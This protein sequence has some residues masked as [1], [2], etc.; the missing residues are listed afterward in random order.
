[1]IQ[2]WTLPVYIANFILMDYGTARSS[3]VRRTTS[4]TS[5]LPAST[6]SGQ[7][8]GDAGGADAARPSRSPTRPIT[9]DGVMINSDFLTA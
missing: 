3:P 1:L 2:D 5:I 6:I 4:A 9:D 7:A 8:G